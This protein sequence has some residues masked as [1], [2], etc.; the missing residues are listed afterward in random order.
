MFRLLLA[1]LVEVA[2]YFLKWWIGRSQDAKV[3]AREIQERLHDET[4]LLIERKDEETSRLVDFRLRVLEQL[5]R[6]R[7]VRLLRGKP[8]G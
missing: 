3:K 6:D 5:L 7:R 2:P 1:L 4:K 8:P